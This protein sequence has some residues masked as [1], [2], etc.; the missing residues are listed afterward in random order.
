M[1][2]KNF[3]IYSLNDYNACAFRFTNP[4]NKK[5]SFH[6]KTLTL[7]TFPINIDYTN[8]CLIWIEKRYLRENGRNPNFYYYIPPAGENGDLLNEAEQKIFSKQ[9]E[10]YGKYVYLLCTLRID[11][12][13]YTNIDEVIDNINQ[14]LAAKNKLLSTIDDEKNKNINGSILKG[15]NINRN[16]NKSF[17][18]DNFELIFNKNYEKFKTTSESEEPGAQDSEDDSFACLAT[19]DGLNCIFNNCLVKGEDN[20][21]STHIN[22]KYCYI[23]TCVYKKKDIDEYVLPEEYTDYYN[24][25]TKNGLT[26]IMRSRY[27]N[28]LNVHTMNCNT[29]IN[30]KLGVTGQMKITTDY[31]YIGKYGW[32]KTV[33]N[34]KD[35]AEYL[36][37]PTMM[38][39]N[40][41]IR[42]Q[43][44][45]KSR[46]YNCSN[47]PNISTADKLYLRVCNTQY[48]DKALEYVDKNMTSELPLLG[49][50]NLVT[51]FVRGKGKNATKIT[52][53]DSTGD[54]ATASTE[55]DI[56][57]LDFSIEPIIINVDVNMTIPPNDTFYLYLHGNNTIYP[58]Y[59]NEHYIEVDNVREVTN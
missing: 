54:V 16:P 9:S 4:S 34:M 32:I 6:I 21:N 38:E 36:L 5:Y 20:L 44:A 52:Q 28:N 2:D 17:L 55:S 56:L 7:Y 8:N 3:R 11:P 1:F 18:V 57:N 48:I 58:L 33:N 29:N 14:K 30:I 47:Q 22:R 53:D 26:A 24:L 23:P 45:A 49:T 43:F 19:F 50:A 13:L 31:M 27:I 46:I 12:G 37:N 42:N 41:E 15:I 40:F 59:N 25:V 35:Y 51:Y 10:Y 39:N